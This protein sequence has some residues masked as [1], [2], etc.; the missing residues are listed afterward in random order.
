MPKRALTFLGG[1]IGERSLE[2][3]VSQSKTTSLLKEASRRRLKDT[4]HITVDL[5]PTDNLPH[6]QKE[7]TILQWTLQRSI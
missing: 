7:V 5:N 1:S 6:G 3:L 4:L 2:R